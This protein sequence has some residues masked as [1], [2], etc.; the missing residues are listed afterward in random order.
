MTSG[1]MGASPISGGNGSGMPWNSSGVELFVPCSRRFATSKQELWLWLGREHQ[2]ATTATG[3]CDPKKQE[4]EREMPV[5]RPAKTWGKVRSVAASVAIDR[6]IS[7]R[8]LRDSQD[9][10]SR[11]AGHGIGHGNPGIIGSV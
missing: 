11:L 2:H 7:C 5:F 1:L 4:R 9:S 6:S 3:P 8:S 10:L